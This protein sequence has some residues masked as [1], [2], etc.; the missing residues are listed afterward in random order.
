M[1]FLE[2]VKMVLVSSLALHALG[3]VTFNRG[4]GFG[5]AELPTT[6]M[7]MAA[8]FAAGWLFNE[9]LPHHD[10][11]VEAYRYGC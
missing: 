3:A 9:V 1:T 8:L 2:F 10:A 7:C 6:V 5:L 4:R 11:C